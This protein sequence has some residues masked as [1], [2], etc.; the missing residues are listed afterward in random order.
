MF[1]TGPDVIKTVTHEEVS[2]EELGGAMTHN[3]HSGVAHFAVDD[4]RACLALIRDLLRFLPSNNLDRAAGRRDDRSARSRGRGARSP[5]AGLAQPA[6]R[7]ARS[8]PLGRRWRRV[9]RSASALR[10]EHHRRVR[11]A[12]RPVGRHRRESAVASGRR[13]RYRR[14]GEGRA[15]RPVLRRVQHPAHHV[16]RRA[17]VS[18]GHRAGVRRHHP[19]RR[20]A[21]VRV[22]RGDRAEG[23]RRSPARRTAARTA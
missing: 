10:A 1:V 16:R 14:V 11:A 22:C 8:H 5:R 21:A 4:D 13:A 19:A 12:R 2:K 9:P 15:V 23:D 17:G 7:H 6:V 3:E 20:Q 18:A